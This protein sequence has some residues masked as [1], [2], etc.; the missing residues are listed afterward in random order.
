MLRIILFLATNLAIVALLGVVMFVLQ[1]FFGIRLG[2]DTGSLLVISAILG[3][4]GAFISLA[5]SKW[6]AKRAS[7]RTS[8]S[9]NLPR[10]PRP[11]A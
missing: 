8:S 1:T 9:I 10:P 5:L 2:R 11:A 4:G 3:F 7:P 6:L